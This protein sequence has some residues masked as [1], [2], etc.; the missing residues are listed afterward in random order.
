[1]KSEYIWEIKIK[2]T[3]TLKRKCNHCSS[4]SFYCSD[5][6]RMNAQKRNID[7]WLIYRCTKC[8][9][10]YNLTLLSRSKPELIE[11][12]LFCKFS[13]NNEPLAW[14]Y[15]FSVETL[16]KNNVE[17]DYSSVVYEIVH[18][19]V[20]IN[21]ILSSNNEFITFRIQTRFE[22][23]LK[24]LSVIRSCLGLSTNQLRRMIEAKAIFTSEGYPLKKHKVR[25]GDV[26][27]VSREKL[28]EI[29]IKRE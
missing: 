1:M 16:R 15:A 2:N 8:D 13:E 18:D 4:N 27:M 17:P 7:V 14:E 5:R 24:L 3:P 21:D 23:G 12:D 22:F 19:A 26:V 11:K 29:Y 28:R 25:N 9:S 6:F 20:S 10:T